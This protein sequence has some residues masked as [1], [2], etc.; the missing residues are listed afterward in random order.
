MNR[1]V[2]TGI[3]SVTPLGGTFESSWDSV[4]SGRSGICK[5]TKINS[6]GLKLKAAGEICDFRQHSYLSTK[7]FNFV[8]PFTVY[9]IAA[10]GEAVKS[11]GLL[12]NTDCLSPAGIVIGSS[13]GGIST[14]E[15]ELLKIASNKGRVRVSA[16]VMP[17]STIS[18]AASYVAMK[19]GIRGHCLGISSACASGTNAIGESFRMIRS[20]TASVILAG[21]AEAPLCMSCIEGYGAAGALSRTEPADASRPFDVKRDGFVPAEG[22]CVM[23]LEDLGSALGRN[24]PI[25][26]EIIGYG[27]ACDAFH[28]TR[29]SC[30]GEVRAMLSALKDAEM[31]SR[32]IDYVNAHGTSTILGDK[33]EARAINNLF[34]NRDI[35]VSSVKSM[36]GHMLAASGAFEAACT[37]MSLNEGFIPA[38]INTETV[39]PECPID[40]ITSPVSMPLKVAITNSFGFGGVNAVLVLRKYLP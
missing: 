35:P 20:G 14:L 33:V 36:T 1:V 18:S 11:A 34:G 8:D 13:R 12:S 5:I 6:A 30:E 3:G 4:R 21:G 24:A 37:A 31:S 29:P 22:A 15:K 23:V 9:A 32:D 19:L 16:H 10:A 17:S 39:D 38:T 7:E 27:N 40:L 26:G 2:I 25:L 28:P